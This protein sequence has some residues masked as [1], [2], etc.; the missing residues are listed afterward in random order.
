M[1]ELRWM[2]EE[3]LIKWRMLLG[4]R[5][6]DKSFDDLILREYELAKAFKRRMD[7]GHIV[8]VMRGPK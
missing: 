1:K 3:Q 7:Y 2:T 6:L 4:L 8:S 5:P